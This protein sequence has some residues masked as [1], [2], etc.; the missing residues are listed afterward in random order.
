MYLDDFTRYRAKM[1][2]RSRMIVIALLACLCSARAFRVE[3]GPTIRLSRAAGRAVMK[4]HGD[5]KE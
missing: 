1:S 5:V 4:R 3:G 2:T